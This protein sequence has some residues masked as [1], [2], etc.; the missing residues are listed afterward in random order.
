MSPALRFLFSF[1]V[2]RFSNNNVEEGN[3]HRGC[4]QLATPTFWPTRAVKPAQ[5]PQGRTLVPGGVP[6]LGSAV[7]PP[8]QGG[9]GALGRGVKGEDVE[10]ETLCSEKSQDA[11]FNHQD[12]SPQA[13]C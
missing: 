1:W 2:R 9:R 13:C 8:T 11:D 3:T 5:R 7:S 12:G 6:W 10:S 4:E